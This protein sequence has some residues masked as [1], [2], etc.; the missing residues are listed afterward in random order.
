MLQMLELFALGQHAGRDH[1]ADGPGKRLHERL[2]VVQPL[3]LV[4]DDR[5]ALAELVDQG[6]AIHAAEQVLGTH[7]VFVFE[8]L[9][10]EHRRAGED[11]QAVGA[12][13]APSG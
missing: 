11:D 7:L 5:H 1:G 3:A 8:Q 13:V 10:V 2:L 4:A 6:R 9:A 12:L